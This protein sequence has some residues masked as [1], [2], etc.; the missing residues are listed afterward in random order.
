MPRLNS[1][2]SLISEFRFERPNHPLFFYYSLALLDI[3]VVSLTWNCYDFSYTQH[4]EFV[5][6]RRRNL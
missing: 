4:D 3:L 6:I 1:F 5:K 2:D